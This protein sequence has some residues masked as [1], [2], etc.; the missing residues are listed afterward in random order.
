MNKPGPN[1]NE[2]TFEEKSPAQMA[3]DTLFVQKAAFHLL[4]LKD[5]DGK[6]GD[7][8]D[9]DVAAIEAV[10][11]MDV[12]PAKA[13]AMGAL[14]GLVPSEALYLMWARSR[15]ALQ[16]LGT[17]GLMRLADKMDNARAPGD[18]RVLLKIVEWAGL[19][20][21][22]EAPQDDADRLGKMTQADIGQLSDADLHA[23]LMAQ[24]KRS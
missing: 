14:T 11:E 23:K 21:P 22:Q 3:A 1:P 5:R 7:M 20:T 19:P 13:A 16:L 15:N 9:D 2:P 8:T 6:L 18:T 12:M 17:V 4:A 10:S 24:L